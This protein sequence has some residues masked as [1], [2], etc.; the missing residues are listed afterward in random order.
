VSFWPGVIVGI[1]GSYIAF[2]LVDLWLDRRK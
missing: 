1:V 2:V